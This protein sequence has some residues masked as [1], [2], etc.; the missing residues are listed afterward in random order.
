[1]DELFLLSLTPSELRTYLALRHLSNDSG[2]V[3][4]TMVE[5][6]EVTGYSRE[7]IRLAVRELEGKGLVATHRTKRNLGRLYKNEYQLLQVDL[8]STAVYT[9]TDSQQ[10]TLTTKAINTSYLLGATAPREAKM[11]KEIVLNKWNPDADDNIAGVG[12]FDNEIAI[13][14]EGTKVSKRDPKTR[15]LRSE[16]EWTA[17]DVAS[18]FSS[19]V[20]ARVRGIPGLVN[21]ANVRGALAKWRKEHGITADIELEIMGMYFADERFLINA[22]KNP[23]FIVGGFL[24]MFTTHLDKALEN[25]GLPQ[26]QAEEP[27]VAD[28]ERR[29]Y[30]YAS[31]GKAFDNSLPGRKARDRYELSIKGK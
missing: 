4:A 30:V 25:L 16:S 13:A 9:D 15:Y 24:R 1:M 12:R 3:K 27:L 7:S 19:R 20:Y 6:G 23:K 31:D 11:K 10:T 29:V 8:A 2:L 26:I 28:S 14:R 18:E 17:A 5:L 21:T 22:K